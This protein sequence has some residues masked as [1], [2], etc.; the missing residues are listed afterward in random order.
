M[1]ALL[2][3]LMAKSQS[4]FLKASLPFLGQVAVNTKSLIE[5]GSARVL[6]P[7]S[8]DKYMCKMEGAA[9]KLAHRMPA[10]FKASLP[11]IAL[12][13][14]DVNFNVGVKWPCNKPSSVKRGIFYDALGQT[15]VVPAP[16]FDKL[17]F[18]LFS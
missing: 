15:V 4:A 17:L 14:F 16:S 11:P 12:A 5:L 18:V 1:P 2:Y 9:G 13:Y 8:R 6:G 7:L 3:S 10:I